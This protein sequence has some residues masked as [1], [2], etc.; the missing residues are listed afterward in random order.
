[1]AKKRYYNS[2]RKKDVMIPNS[3][4]EFAC[5]H[6]TSF[7]AFFP[8]EGSNLMYTYRDDLSAIDKQ[9]STDKKITKKQMTDIKY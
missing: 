6:Q 2:T 9:M 4:N 8:K 7:T 1:M 5:M 3:L